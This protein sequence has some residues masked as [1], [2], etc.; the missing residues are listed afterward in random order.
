[1]DEL[2]EKSSNLAIERDRLRKALEILLKAYL[3]EAKTY[4][5]GASVAAVEI[6]KAALKI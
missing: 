5:H 3:W 1:M 2:L 4:G 6:A